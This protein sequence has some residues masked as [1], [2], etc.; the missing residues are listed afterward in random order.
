PKAKS[1]TTPK[2][3]NS[4]AVPIAAPGSIWSHRLMRNSIA[5]ITFCMCATAVSAVFAVATTQPTT[6]PVAQSDD[7]TILL[8][9]RDVI[10]HG[11]TVRYEP[12]PDKNTV[13]YWTKKDD[14]VSW[15]FSVEK[16]GKFDV[17]ALQG[18]GK[19][20]GGAEVEFI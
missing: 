18:C 15:N 10:I 4:S 16:P 7:G 8:H 3:T 11:S 13:G 1:P 17:I 20:S 2:P 19:G 5:L 14:W 6:K 12:Q 9:S